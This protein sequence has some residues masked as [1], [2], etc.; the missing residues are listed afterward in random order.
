VTPVPDR[1]GPECSVVIHSFNRRG[2]LERALS[3]LVL[4]PRVTPPTPTLDVIVSDSGSTDG[5]RELVRQRYP[6]VR[7][8]ELPE[9]RGLAAG[10]NAGMRVARGS[11]VLV[12]DEDVVITRDQLQHLIEVMKVHPEAGMLTCCKVDERDEALYQHHVPTPSSMNLLFFVMLEWSIVES[13]RALKKLLN[14]GER[15]PHERKDIAEIPF[16]GGAFQ[17]VRAEAVRQVGP[18]D[19]NIF[20]YGEDFDWCYRFRC[21]GWKILYLPQ[22]KVRAFHGTNSRRTMRASLVALRSRRYLFLK[23]MGAR[24]LPLYW[25][26]ALLGLVPKTGY[27]VAQWARGRR[28]DIPLGWWLWS[29][30][31]TIFGAPPPVLLKGS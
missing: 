11:F 19:E 20:F 7:L 4:D 1:N 14:V 13:L 5:S 8:V 9:D 10:R 31:R 2:Y 16:V 27:Y 24:F 22:M 12:M 23:Y 18:C 28:D 15:R 6:E 26:L 21:C 25:G 30:V 3:A 17:F 29:A